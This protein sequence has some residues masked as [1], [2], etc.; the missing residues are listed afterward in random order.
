MQGKTH[1]TIGAAVGMCVATA[2]P[3]NVSGNINQIVLQV[4]AS[5]IG[6]LFADLD[7]ENSKGGKILNK[8]LGF[9]SAIGVAGFLGLKLGVLELGKLNLNWNSFV[10][11]VAFLA[12]G[13]YSRTRPHREFTHSIMVMAVTTMLLSGFTTMYYWVWYA[14]GYISHLVIDFPNKK[15]ESLLWPL[16]QKFCLQLC[17]ANGIADKILYWVGIALTTILLFVKVGVY[18]V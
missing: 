2:M 1:A 4:G 15:G 14:A 8:V 16:K 17:T 13:V 9:I 18:R 5:V 11:F 7:I 12:I 6:A 10:C 3:D